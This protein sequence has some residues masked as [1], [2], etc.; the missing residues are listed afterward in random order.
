MVLHRRVSFRSARIY[1]LASMVAAA[2]IPALHIPVWSVAPIEIPMVAQTAVETTTQPLIATPAPVDPIPIALGILWSVGIVV[3]GTVMVRQFVKIARIRRGAELLLTDECRIA[4]SDEVG[5]PFSFLGTMFIERGTS[6]ADM[7]QI[8]LHEASHIRHR[9]SQEKIAMEVFKNLQ[10]FNPFAWWAASLLAEVHEFEA[11]R[12]VLDGGSTVEEYL[13][14]IFRQ[15]FGYIPELSVGLGDSLTKKRFQM[16]RNKM[17]PAKFGLLRVAGALPLA[18]GMM[19]LFSFTS[20]PPEIIFTET[21]AVVETPA[22]VAAEIP[23]HVETPAPQPEPAPQTPRKVDGDAPIYVAEVMPTFQGGGLDVFRN[24]VQQQLRY[25]KEAFEN[26]IQGQVTVQFVIERDGS[27]STIT[28][29]NSPAK[30]LT[31]ETSRVLLTSPKW[32]PGI[33]GGKPARVFYVL[34]VQFRLQEADGSAKTTPPVTDAPIPESADRSSTQ[35]LTVVGYGTQR[36]ESSEATALPQPGEIRFLTDD[37]AAGQPMVILD[38]QEI[39]SS[40]IKAIDPET[41]QTISVLKNAA[42][43]AAYGERAKDGVV[44][45]T[46][47]KPDDNNITSVKIR[48]EKGTPMKII[49]GIKQ[50]LREANVIKISYTTSSGETVTTEIK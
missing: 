4:L 15:I 37:I 31:D 17:K 19:A 13:E 46:S 50:R 29:L 28:E 7:R 43:T 27:L 16:M 35:G 8:V 44:L 45:I 9:H 32:S 48:A 49:D 34:P 21:P 42:A 22:A 18:A 41:I 30:V 39:L 23:V 20:R 38:G 33:H 36:R 3:L 12:D 14:L 10:W 1:L 40:Q 47:K 24:W 6:D 2:V 11:D 5:S 25:P 26:N